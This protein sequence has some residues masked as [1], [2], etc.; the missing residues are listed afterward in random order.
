MS[1]CLVGAEGT[2]RTHTGEVGFCRDEDEAMGGGG[3]GSCGWETW[4]SHEGLLDAALAGTTLTS[5]R[6]TSQAMPSSFLGTSSR[7]TKSKQA[8]EECL[9]LL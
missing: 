6:W 2:C 3:E 5:L 8:S 7:R 1:L 9:E 4:R